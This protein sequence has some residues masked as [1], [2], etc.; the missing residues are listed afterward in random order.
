MKNI[1]KYVPFLG[2]WFGVPFVKNPTKPVDEKTHQIAMKEGFATLL[3]HFMFI[4][5][6]L[7]ILVITLKN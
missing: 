6:P 4:I 1:L 5:L 2:L 7:S 3:Y